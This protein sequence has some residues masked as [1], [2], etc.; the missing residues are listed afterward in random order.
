MSAAPALMSVW[1]AGVAKPAGAGTGSQP[2]ETLAFYR[3][4]TEAL[5]RRYMQKSMEVGRTP[6]ILGNCMFRGRVS[7]RRLRNFEENVIFVIDVEKGLKLLDRA[8]QNVISRIALQEYSQGETAA[9][10]GQSLRSIVRKYAEA[11]DALTAIFL[12]FG[13]LEIAPEKSCQ[14]GR[15]R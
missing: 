14:G 10:L 1:A 8:S 4:H 13:L 9:L 6:S 11:L 2:I 15:N 3:R 5:L 12:D 7:S